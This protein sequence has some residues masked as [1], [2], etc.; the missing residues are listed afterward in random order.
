MSEKAKP[1]T[2][3]D[4]P[5][6]D[7]RRKRPAPPMPDPPTD[8]PPP[9]PRTQPQPPGE[10]KEVRLGAGWEAGLG[11]RLVAAGVD[12][13]IALALFALISFVLP[14]IGGGFLAGALAATYLIARDSLPF[15]DGQSPGKKVVRLKVADEAGNRLVANWRPA[16]L[17]NFLLII[18]L[19]FLLEL[20]VLLSGRQ[21]FGDTWAGTRVVRAL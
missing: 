13:G 21:R 17:R 16:F 11:P 4:K 19:G 7:D 18:P 15:L 20:F 8:A 6:R 2:D 10:S 12:G 5:G 1:E 9:D 3:E 14:G